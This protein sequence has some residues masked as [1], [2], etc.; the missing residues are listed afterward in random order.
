M[1]GG[2]GPTCDISLPK[3]EHPLEKQAENITTSL[4]LTS[5]HPQKPGNNLLFLNLRQLN[6]LAIMIVLAAS[7]MVSPG[8]FAIFVFSVIYIFFLSNFAYPTYNNISPTQQKPVF[9]QNNKILNIYI[10]FAGVIGLLFPILYIFHGILEGD[11]DGIKAAAPH[12]FLLSSQVFMEGVSI[13]DRFSLPIRVFIPVFF[14]SC[15]MYTLVEWLKE[16]MV[17]VVE[18]RYSGSYSRLCV[19]RALAV[20]NF[21]LWSYNLFGFLLP[22]YLPRAFK[23]YYSGNGSTTLKEE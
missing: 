18:G 19:G 23:R 8:D 22:V 15:R 12:V 17:K 4:N 10:I 2:V 14:N 1:S 7:G 9:D 6:C 16:E 20:A 3:E 11:Q 13:S 5:K 21:V